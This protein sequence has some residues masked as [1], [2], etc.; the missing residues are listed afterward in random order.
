M[1]LELHREF[2]SDVFS[3]APT[4]SRQQSICEAGHVVDMRSNSRVTDSGP[5]DTTRENTEASVSFDNDVQSSAG[6]EDSTELDIGPALSDVLVAV[7]FELLSGPAVLSVAPWQT[8]SDFD[9]I[10][11]SF[12]KQYNI[13]PLFAS[14]LVQHLEEVEAE[15][16]T[17]PYR[18]KSSLADLY[19]RYG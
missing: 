4:I 18:V 10:V 19:S 5:T 6:P 17:F 3:Q 11:Q 9:G 14:A 12:L 16:P 13:K 15:A 8:R 1:K 2:G 7:E